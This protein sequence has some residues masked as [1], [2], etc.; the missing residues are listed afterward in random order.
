M[1]L[2]DY[3]AEMARTYKRDR[4]DNHVLGLIGETGEV[5]DL[6]KKHVY[7]ESLSFDE[8][9]VKMR[10]E[11]GDCLWYLFALMADAVVD[12]QGF[13]SSVVT[14]DHV[15][16]LFQPRRHEG[17]AAVVYLMHHASASIASA[18]GMRFD[19]EAPRV[20]MWTYLGNVAKLATRLNL[21]LNDIA[22]GNVAKLKARYPDGFVKGGGVRDGREL[23]TKAP[24]T[25]IGSDVPG[26]G[27]A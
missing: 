17:F 21:N 6:L 26:G 20:A 8:L 19:D 14:F 23:L 5:A 16:Q 1:T 18:M 2:N 15:Q 9:R 3:F 11:L 7:H 25:D 27:A 4:Q 12:P 13:D 22:E 24:S 10:D